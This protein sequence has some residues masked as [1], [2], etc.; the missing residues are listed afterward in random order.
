MSVFDDAADW[1]LFFDT[2]GA[3]EMVIYHPADGPDVALAGIFTA[4]HAVVARGGFDGGVSTVTPVLTLPPVH[5]LP[6]ADLVA[7]DEVTCRAVLYRV[8]DVQP[9]GSGMIRLILERA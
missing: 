1:R 6:V 4:A 5:H 7:G 2:G 3:G 8:A 9:D